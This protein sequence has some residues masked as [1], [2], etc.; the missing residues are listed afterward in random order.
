MPTYTFTR[1]REQMRDMV[2]RKLN[3][4]GIDETAN[5]EDAVL[6]YEAMDIRLKELHSLNLLWFEVASALSDVTITSGSATTNAGSDVLYPV[7][8]SVRVGSEDF[9]LEIVDHRTFQAIPNKTETGQPEKMLFSGGVYRFWPVPDANYTGKLTYQQMAAD[10]AAAAAP[11]VPVAMM[12]SLVT[13]IVYDLADDYGLSEQAISRLA[14]QS[15]G[16][17]RTIRALNAQRVDNKTVEV[18]YF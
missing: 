2:L 3:A 17:M 15:E 9:P 7:S 13:L 10:T 18:S 5:A 12:R 14:A 1:T 8:M 11:N 16:A 4:L 6:V